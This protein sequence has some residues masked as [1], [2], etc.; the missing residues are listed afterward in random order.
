MYTVLRFEHPGVSGEEIAT[1]GNELNRIADG[2]FTDV[3][4]VENRFSCSLSIKSSPDD[5]ISEAVSKVMKLVPTLRRLSSQN[6][7]FEIDVALEEQPKAAYET[8]SFPPTFLQTLGSINCRL[9]VTQY[10]SK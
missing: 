5:H 10:T 6:W 2:L 8:F 7:E 4:A 3:D 1:V 9:T